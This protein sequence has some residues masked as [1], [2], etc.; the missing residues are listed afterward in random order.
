[1]TKAVIIFAISLAVYFVG[2]GVFALVKFIKN[3]RKIDKDIK[4]HEKEQSE[5]HD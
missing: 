5:N 4:S 1:M 3:K 2:I